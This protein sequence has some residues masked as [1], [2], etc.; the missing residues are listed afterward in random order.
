MSCAGHARRAVRWYFDGYGV[1]LM[2][3]NDAVRIFRFSVV[4][5]PLLPFLLL[6]PVI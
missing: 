3:V 4:H 5:I 1:S 6:L 2:L